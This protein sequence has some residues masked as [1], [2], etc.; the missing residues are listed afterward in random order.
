MAEGG[1][2]NRQGPTNI[3]FPAGGFTPRGA[4]LGASCA[5]LIGWRCG[6]GI[7]DHGASAPCRMGALRPGPVRPAADSAGGVP[8]PG[9][10]AWRLRPLAGQAMP[11]RWR[12]RCASSSSGPGSRTNAVPSVPPGTCRLPSTAPASASASARW[13]GHHAD[14]WP[15]PVLGARRFRIPTETRR[16]RKVFAGGTSRGGFVAGRTCSIR[17]AGAG[18]WPCSQ[19]FH[20]DE[21]E[22]LSSPVW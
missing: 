15:G 14:C 2:G 7:P 4:C 16:W 17:P 19:P 22:R 20:P 10:G 6:S 1:S 11:A 8:A 9:C 12:R 13:R 18:R 5:A 21:M 3:A